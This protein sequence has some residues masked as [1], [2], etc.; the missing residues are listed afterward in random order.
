MGACMDCGAKHGELHHHN[1]A[2]FE[3]DPLPLGRKF[4]SDK[5]RFDLLLEGM[6]RALQEVTKV[7]TAGA[8]KYEEHNWQHVEDAPHR[9]LAAGMRHE[10]ALAMGEIHDPETRL[11]HLAHKL[12]CDLFRLELVLREG[13]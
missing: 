1:C 11:H 4:D 12:C 8:V 6:P 9:Y 5:P 2:S 3:R 10:I 13:A 7:L